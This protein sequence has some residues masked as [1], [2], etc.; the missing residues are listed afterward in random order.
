MKNPIV[1]NAFLPIAV[2]FLFPFFCFAQSS[3]LPHGGS[4]SLG[5]GGVF[6]C[7]PGLSGSFGNPANLANLSTFEADL[8]Y[9][10]RFQGSGIRE[11]GVGLGTRLMQGALGVSFRHLGAGAYREQLL[12]LS[13]GRSLGSGLDAGIRFDGGAV[14]VEGNGSRFLINGSLGVQAELSSKVHTGFMVHHPFRANTLTS[15]FMPAALIIGLRYAPSDQFQLL[16]DCFRFAMQPVG[17][18]FGLE[19]LPHPRVQVRAGVGIA[20]YAFSFGVGIGMNGRYRMQTALSQH[21]FLGFSPAFGI[22]Y[23]GRQ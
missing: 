2:F 13:Y 18:R 5:M 8:L 9:E 3:F 4:S 20:P 11:V 14:T 16:A 17:L 12:Q 19:Y 15:A 1:I 21:A 7:L 22:H 23:Q 10:S 6:V